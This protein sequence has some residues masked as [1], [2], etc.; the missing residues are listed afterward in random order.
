M[1]FSL[2]LLLPALLLITI[3]GPVH[4]QLSHLNAEN[5]ALGGG[6]TAYVGGYHANFINPANLMTQRNNRN[7]LEFGLFGGLNLNSGGRL[8]DF[9]A[10]NTHFASGR[11]LSGPAKVE[12]LDDLLGTN[13][14]ELREA[15]LDLST[16][17]LGFS[18]RGEK[19]A[20]SAALRTRLFTEFGFNRGFGDL[21]LNGFDTETFGQARAVNMRTRVISMSEVSVGYSQ[22]LLGFELPFFANE[23]QLFGGVAPKLLIGN[24]YNDLNLRSTLQM[25]ERSFTD[26]EITHDFDYSVQVS[27]NQGEQLRQ[28][29]EANQDPNQTANF[30]E[31]IDPSASDFTDF[32]NLGFGVDLGITMQVEL[33]KVPSL[34]KNRNS[35][36][37]I[38]ASITDIGSVTFG[39]GGSFRNNNQLF[40]NGLNLSFARVEQDFNDDLGE[41]I[42]YVFADSI[43]NGV[44]GSFEEDNREITANLPTRFQMG[45][46]LQMNNFAFMVDISKGFTDVGVSNESFFYAVGTEY[47]LFRFIPIRVG[48]RNGDAIH[49][50]FSV[51]SGIDTRFFTFTVAASTAPQSSTEGNGLGFA[52]SGIVLRF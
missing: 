50:S 41:Y 25:N 26:V 15:G 47:R 2:N 45:G 38:G 36:L 29:A 11:N 34:F 23:I 20:F 19:R 14:D 40:W 43:A 24:Y 49:P 30:R 18:Y 13:Y 48:Y 6:G 16:V 33:D 37:R 52:W 46:H 5:M 28:Y 39:N 12:A 8:A 42:N 4:G 31:Y 44:Y 3:A 1:R 7:N 32:S 27:G 9:K 10:Y 51:G 17:L 35:F 21:M 22:K